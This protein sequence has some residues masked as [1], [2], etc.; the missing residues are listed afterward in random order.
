[1]AHAKVKRICIPARFIGLGNEAGID[2]DPNDVL[3]RRHRI[4]AVAAVQNEVLTAEE[5]NVLIRPAGADS[6]VSRHTDAT[7]NPKPRLTRGYDAQIACG[8]DVDHAESAL[9]H[10]PNL[11]SACADQLVDR[12]VA[13]MKVMMTGCEFVQAVL[14]RNVSVGVAEHE[15]DST[16]VGR[17]DG[18]S[19]HTMR[20]WRDPAFYNGAEG[21]GEIL[22][23]DDPVV[24]QDPLID[25]QIGL[26]PSGKAGAERQAAEKNRRTRQDANN[27]R[28]EAI[29]GH[30][31]PFQ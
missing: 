6:L 9:G 10:A 23:S 4:L 29:C 22:V 2:G 27:P 28:S 12:V 30:D 24:L 13:E 3:A 19:Q 26:C 21:R 14:S 17:V 7:T 31:A 5:P 25:D 18:E 16:D 1:M 15:I 11:P 8:L 20:P